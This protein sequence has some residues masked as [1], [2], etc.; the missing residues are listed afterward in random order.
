MTRQLRKCLVISGNDGFPQLP[1]T[2]IHFNTQWTGTPPSH[3]D[4]MSWKD[5][6]S[7]GQDKSEDLLVERQKKMAI[8]H[9]ATLVY[10]SGT[11]GMPK[12]I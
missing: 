5:L 11:T 9:C 8:N 10:T 12:G 4:V 2:Y 6:V 7:L 3:P 1:A